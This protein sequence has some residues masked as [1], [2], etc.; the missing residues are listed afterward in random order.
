M[1]IGSKLS[2]FTLSEEERANKKKT[3]FELDREYKEYRV[4]RRLGIEADD[5]MHNASSITSPVDV[6]TFKSESDR[7][8]FKEKIYSRE[9]LR[10]IKIA[11]FDEDFEK[12]T[13]QG[14]NAN[15]V[16]EADSQ[17]GIGESRTLLTVVVDE[18]AKRQDFLANVKK[19]PPSQPDTETAKQSNMQ[20]ARTESENLM[21]IARS[22]ISARSAYPM[23]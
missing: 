7:D 1:K 3:N 5:R 18:Y 21:K 16:E 8:I 17:N 6:D 2:E 4:S 12:L 22:L 11:E 9:L 10:K 20:I 15:Y 13:N 14:A 23:L 19:E